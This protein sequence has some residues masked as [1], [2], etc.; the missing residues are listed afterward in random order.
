L[1]YLY[2]ISCTEICPISI[3]RKKAIQSYFF[4]IAIFLGVLSIGIDGYQDIVLEG[5]IGEPYEVHQGGTLAII[6][7]SAE[8]LS[9]M[10]FLICFS[11][12]GIEKYNNL[13]GVLMSNTGVDI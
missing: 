1:E 3:Y 7:D 5:I 8:L 13:L 10:F 4:A 11:E 2:Y 6:E 12:F 9:S